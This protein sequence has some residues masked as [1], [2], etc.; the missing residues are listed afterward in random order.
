MSIKPS[1]TPPKESD[2]EFDMSDI[3]IEWEIDK[4]QDNG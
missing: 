4:G 3:E 1:A 2:V